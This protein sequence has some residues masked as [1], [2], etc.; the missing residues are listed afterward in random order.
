M[1]GINNPVI[2]NDLGYVYAAEEPKSYFIEGYGTGKSFDNGQWKFETSFGENIKDFYVNDTRFHAGIVANEHTSEHENII[3]LVNG[4]NLQ[5]LTDN[6]ASDIRAGVAVMNSNVKLADEGK[7]SVKFT[8]SMPDTCRKTPVGEEYRKDVGGDGITFFIT[9]ADNAIQGGTGGAMG[10][11]GITD[12]V[13]VEFDSFYNTGNGQEYYDPAYNGRYIYNNRSYNFNNGTYNL[14][15]YKRDH[16]AVV[17]GGANNAEADHI[18]TEFLYDYRGDENQYEYGFTQEGDLSVAIEEADNKLFT[19]W[20]EYDGEKLYVRCA[21]GDFKTAD[22]E[23][24]ITTIVDDPRVINQLKE[25]NGEEVK[26]GF[27]AAIASSKANHTIHSIAFV[28]EYLENGISTS[29]TAKYYVEDAN[30]TENYIDVEVDGIT[31]RYTLMDE[32]DVYDVLYDTAVDIADVENTASYVTECQLVDYSLKGYPSTADAI[33]LDGSTV[34]YQ[35]Y[36][37]IHSYEYTANGNEITGECVSTD[38]SCDSEVEGK[39]IVIT[40]EDM[41]A[42]GTAYDGASYTDDLSGVTGDTTTGIYYEG[43][44]STNYPRTTTPPTEAGTYKAIVEIDGVE[45]YDEFEISEDHLHDW[46]YTPDDENKE[47]TG[48]CTNDLCDTDTADRKIG[49]TADDMIYT[50]NPY[51]KATYTDNLSEITKDPVKIYYEGVGDT[52]YPQSANPPTEVGTYKVTVEIDEVTVEE[53]FNILPHDH[54]WEYT[55]NKNEITADCVT[56]EGTCDKDVEGKKITITADNTD[57]TGAQYSDD[58]IHIS[59]ELTEITGDEVKIYFEGP[60]YPRTEVPPTADGIYKA[61]ISITDKDGNVTEAFDDFEIVAHDHEWVYEGNGNEITGS[62]EQDEGIC[63]KGV[64]DKKVT[65][66]AADMQYSG[67]P[68]PESNLTVTDNLLE[69]TG[70]TKTIYYEGTGDTVYEKSITPPTDVGT[71]KAIIEL[72]DKKGN[73]IIDA[74]G[75]PVTA[76]DPFEITPHDHIW[77][78]EGEGNKITADCTQIDGECDKAP[79]EIT[80]EAADIFYTGS[81]YEE[82]NLTIEDELLDATESTKTVYYVGDGD[83][84]YTKSTTPP[85]E[86]GTYKAIIELTDKDG[87]LIVDVN[88]DPV[89]AEDPFEI[90]PHVHNWDYEVVEGTTNEIV[91]ECVE[92]NGKCEADIEGEKIVINTEDMYYTGSSYDKTDFKDDISATTGDT[93]SQITY[94]GIDG[95]TYP[96]DTNPPT[97]VGSYKAVVTITDKEGNVAEAYD[98]FDILEHEHEWKYEVDTDENIIV[99]ECTEDEKGDCTTDTTDKYI[100]IVA[101]DMLYTGNSYPEDKWEVTDTLSEVTG[102]EVK[103]YFVGVDGTNYP[104]SETPPTEVGNYEAIVEI[105]EGDN[106]VSVS[107]PFKITPHDHIWEYEGEGNKITADCTQTEGECDKTTVEIT[108]VADDIFYTGSEYEESNLTFGGDLL[109][110]TGKKKVVYYEGIGETV[111]AKSTTPPTEVGT[112]KA[113]VVLEGI[114][115]VEASDDFEI[116]PHT[117]EWKYTANGNEIIGECIATDGKCEAEIAGKKIIVNAADMLADGNPYAGASYTDD[118]S[119]VTGDTTTGIYYEGTGSTNYPRT[120]TPPTEAGTYKAI[121]EIDGVEAYDEFEI[122]EDHL[123]DWEY[124]PDDEN[125]EITGDCTNDLCDTDTADRKIGLTA[126]DMI[127]TGNP[128][129]KATYTDNL[130]EITK[131]PVKIYYEGV[132]D[133][134][135]PQSANPPTEVGTYKVTVEIDGIKVEKEFKILPDPTHTHD[136]TYTA[137]GNVITGECVSNTGECGTDTTG[138]K[139]VLT[140]TDMV[141]TGNQYDK[142]SYTDNL[143]SVTGDTVIGILYEGVGTTNYPASTTPPTEVGNYKAIVEIDGV[144]VEQEFKITPVPV[145]V[146]DW[147]GLW[148]VTKQPTA[149]ENGSK[150][151]VCQNGCGQKQTAVIP[152]YGT[153]DVITLEKDESPKTGW[154]DNS[155]YWMLLLLLSG[156]GIVCTGGLFFKK[157]K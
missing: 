43:T 155:G 64:T 107:D 2:G 40:A 102:D 6:D 69:V 114:N 67:S 80:I 92:L 56:T 13:G 126:D 47:I 111:Y 130:S 57:Y 63:D 148:Q 105:G 23:N 66:E 75:D 88:G 103:V 143:S 131:D 150:E 109:T 1:G 125:K 44:G 32:V 142:A 156:L 39:K 11:A 17:A 74:N 72:T 76:E 104:K 98:T 145:H 121:V 71:Y 33:E 10:Y 101:E 68:Y 35:F 5:D 100:G 30:A 15:K 14:L 29:Y 151:T 9:K 116:K 85:T 136:W 41:L 135:Y 58:N 99:G 140:A 153:Q 3:R 115:G 106:K 108:I 86:V 12:S 4:V 132:G 70:D 62:C 55:A 147:T 157:D 152:A 77:E 52:T 7:F 138:K 34:L 24:A 50:G 97:E 146:H 31:K 65:I 53:E 122:S 83:T 144:R 18:G 8:F 59:D 129:D 119:G 37:H 16:I 141:Y 110:E 90:K 48:D 21:R 78:Y 93:V 38:G 87:N 27:T 51:D 133:T 42:D 128:Y 89:T 45:A 84:T 123:H 113:I 28:N 22:R 26:V 117:H 94:V 124:T 19:A 25:F 49:L 20:I 54:D 61:V 91:G 36:D 154:S 60:G 112:Y 73:V 46:E 79:V 96:E 82:S 134:T 81:E 120:T 127:Y 137:N 139:I 95:T 118:L 149:T